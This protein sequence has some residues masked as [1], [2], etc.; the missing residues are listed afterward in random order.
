[1]QWLTGREIPLEQG[2]KIC[3]LGL[4]NGFELLAVGDLDIGAHIWGM[5]LEVDL[6]ILVT[7]DLF[8]FTKE[9]VCEAWVK[10][11]HCRQAIFGWLY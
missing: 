4:A 1:M 8:L 7:E 9:R 6:Q 5:V 10:T 11:G 2:I 3:W